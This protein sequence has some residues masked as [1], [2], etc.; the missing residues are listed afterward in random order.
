M[1]VLSFPRIF[2]TGF[3]C[4]DPA[5]GNNNDYFPTY[6]DVKASL[7]WSFFRTYGINITPNNYRSTFRPWV[8]KNQKIDFPSKQKPTAGIPGEWNYFGGNAA[9]FVQYSDPDRGINRTSTITGGMIEHGKPVG[10]D[11]LI[12][13]SVSLLGDPFGKP[14]VPFGK[15]ESRPRGR[16]IDNNPVSVYSAQ[17]YFHSMEFGDANAS[18]TAPRADRMQ[19]RFI[20]FTRN[21]N[22]PAAGGASVT[23]QACF[24]AGSTLKINVGQSQLLAA[25]QAAIDSGK[26]K[27]IMVRF[28]TYLNLYFQNGYFNNFQPQPKSADDLPAQYEKALKTGTLFS[29]PCY[30][31]VVGTIGPWYADE[32]STCP[33]GRFLA[34]PENIGL[35]NPRGSGPCWHQANRRQGNVPGMTMFKAANQASVQESSGRSGPI[36]VRSPV[37]KSWVQLGV[38]VSEVDYQRNVISI[39]VL[40]TFPEWFWEGEK[41]DFQDIIVGVG[42]GGGTVTPVATLPYPQYA[43]AAYMGGGGIVDLPFDPTHAQAIRDGLLEFQAQPSVWVAKQT[44]PDQFERSL[45]QTVLAETPLTAQT[46]QRSIFLN[47]G[48]KTTFQISVKN[49]GAPA[50]GANVLILKYNPPDPPN[51]YSNADAVPANAAQVVNFINGQ[52]MIVTVTTGSG[53]TV[54]T[55]AAVFVADH[56]GIVTVEVEA[57]SPGFPVLVFYP[58]LTGQAQPV[59]PSSFGEFS[60]AMFATIRVLSFDD[61]FVNQ[62]V[63]LWNST[64]DPVQAWNFVYGNILYLYDMIFPVMLNVVPLGERDRVEAAI[65]QVLT[66]IA[67]SYFPESTLA[68]PI[69]RDLSRGKRVVLELWGDLVKKKYP[70][71]PIS[72]GQSRIA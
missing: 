33:E 10:N 1:S 63:A 58:Y 29:N 46:D 2:F 28:N 4:W 5:T 43:Q 40:N 62:F 34:P 20:N 12:G 14:D 72:A 30:S 21:F 9:Y 44:G 15:P 50:S 19:S 52:R 37:L 71:Q 23:W 65:D 68:M 67:T 51:P 55:S 54:Q 16:L 36:N 32:L 56:N 24:P 13:T 59:L 45:T 35:C 26:A 70:P 18:I 39:D 64:F 11:P 7:N 25:L 61:A 57:A 6:D 60:T 69:T 53:A 27:G 17:V 3:M 38:A 47:E 8:I 66:L 49:K 22:L 31:Q 41:A 48:E 42:D